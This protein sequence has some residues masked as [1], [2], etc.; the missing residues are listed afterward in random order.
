MNKLKRL[1][2]GSM[3]EALKRVGG[4]FAWKRKR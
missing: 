4:N 3:K 2:L 1:K